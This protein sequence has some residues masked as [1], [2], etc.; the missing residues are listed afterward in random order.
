MQDKAF[1][2]LKSSIVDAVKLNNPKP[3]KTIYVYTDAWDRF[4]SDV[5]TFFDNLELSRPLLDQYHEPLAFIGKEHS[6]TES[7]WSTFKKDSLPYFRSSK[8]LI[9]CF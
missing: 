8:N 5:V 4:W 6:K 9:T 2:D 3:H 7:K 1:D